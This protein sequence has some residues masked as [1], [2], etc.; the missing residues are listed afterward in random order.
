M[1]EKRIALK[2]TPGLSARLVVLFFLMVFSALA[3]FASGTIESEDGWLYLSVA[4]NAYYT[5]EATA[6]PREYPFKNVNMNSVLSANGKWYA[7][8]AKGYSL[9][10]VPAVFAADLLHRFYG[11]TPPTHF[12]LESDWAVL[13]FA[14]FTNSAITA[15]MAVGI[16]LY[17]YELGF[18][19]KQAII[20]SLVTIFGTLLLPLSKFAFAHP[21]FITGLLFCFYFLKKFANTHQLRYILCAAISYVVVL[22]AY[23]QAY[24]IPIIPLFYYFLSG[25]SPYWRKLVL[26]VASIF[27]LGALFFKPALLH[28]VRDHITFNPK[29]LFEGT[30]GLLFSPGKSFFL[31]SPVLLILLL[32]WWKLSKK[33]KPEIIAFSLLSALFVFLYAKAWILGAA[34]QFTPIWYGGM[35]W[36]TRYIAVLIPFLMILTM[37]CVFQLSKKQQFLLFLPILLIS[38]GVQ[39]VGTSI[40][41]ILQY[42]DLPATINVGLAEFSYYDY[43]SFIPRYS[44]LLVMSAELVKKIAAFPDTI[45]HGTFNVRFYDGWEAP[46]RTGAGYIRGFTEESYLTFTQNSSRPITNMTLRL[47]NRPSFVEATASAKVTVSLNNQPIE[48]FVAPFNTDLT[49]DLAIDSQTLKNGQ[50]QLHLTVDYSPDPVGSHILYITQMTIN[51]ENVN[52]GSLDYPDASAMGQQTTPFPYQYYGNRMND[53][54]KLWYLRARINERTFDFWWIKNIYY[55]DR[56]QRLIWGLFVLNIGVFLGSSWLMYR[57]VKSEKL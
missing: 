40:P 35:V 16:L 55:W 42:R 39:V 22:F 9:A 24:L 28:L 31:Y 49:K 52:L 48:I 53:P 12:P 10:M 57:Q 33:L 19:K 14:S 47:D 27:V 8:G 2:N 15:L 34:G 56:P 45:N 29:I 38:F 30:S 20:T 41:Y 37:H 7:P 50:N 18:T 1:S 25:L 11:S 4:R 36:G 13:F 26:L 32:F 44:P 54:W 43:A 46:I 21:L 23:N 51:G 17:A 6:P 5:G 3:F